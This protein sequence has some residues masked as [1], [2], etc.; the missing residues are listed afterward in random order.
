[1]TDYIEDIRNK[2]VNK[3]KKDFPEFIENNI[4]FNEK[5][6]PIGMLSSNILANW[7]LFNFDKNVL[8]KV[9]PIFYGRYVDDI[10]IVIENNN[11]CTKRICNNNC[12]TE[13][14]TTEFLLNKYLKQIFIKIAESDSEYNLANYNNLIIQSEK[15]KIFSFDANSSIAL[16]TKFK[17]N[18]RKHSSEFRFLPED[19]RIENDLV[20]EG[21]SIDYCDSINKL[22]SIEKY[23]LDK[24]KI[25]S[26]LAKQLTIS[27]YIKDKE[28]FT[29]ILTELMYSF[30][31]R[32]G[33]ELYVYWYKMLIYII[34][35]DDI[36]AFI[37][38]TNV[39]S[40]NIAKIQYTNKKIENILIEH[41]K[42][43]FINSIK[44]FK[45]YSRI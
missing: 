11:T 21:Y 7:Y 19:D 20:Q 18:I 13:E 30:N 38:F 1:M 45:L 37:D 2:Y 25:S 39:I 23:R 14:F 42:T 32:L 3:I 35:N 44:Y 31:G 24:F 15:V 10:L 43:F 16:L 27:K 4:S 5:L 17:D 29:K 22:R 28:H 40:K 8:D 36:N 9:N 41:L 33:L 34:V 12:P 26:F 6:L